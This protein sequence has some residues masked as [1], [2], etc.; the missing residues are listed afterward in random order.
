MVL[1]LSSF[2]ANKTSKEHKWQHV[3]YFRWRMAVIFNSPG[4][5]LPVE[6]P[7][8]TSEEVRNGQVLYFNLGNS[9]FTT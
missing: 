7:V 9:L 6:I 5:K 3:T 1:N 4:P 8:C 2:E